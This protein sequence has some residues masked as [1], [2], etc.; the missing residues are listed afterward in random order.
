MRNRIII[1]LT[2]IVIILVAIIMFLTKSKEVPK[3]ES[4][5]PINWVKIGKKEV[6]IKKINI[7]ETLISDI[8]SSNEL[9]TMEVD[10][11]Q[12]LQWD[13]S[14]GNAG[15]LKKI[16]EVTFYGTGIYT[17]DLSSIEEEDI[18]VDE[19]K[20]SILI[21]IN[22]PLIKQVTID[23]KKTEIKSTENGLLRFGEVKMTIKDSERL[24]STAKEKM[25]YKMT[26]EENTSL[27]NEYTKSAVN[28]LLSNFL[29][30]INI[31]YNINI[32]W[33]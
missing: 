33:K 15:I 25:E 17:T 16:Q 7:K 23:E 11:S 29:K 14:W 13:I 9:I 6:T 31:K 22:K 19:E 2:L 24:R 12:T 21:K 26:L 8:K 18:V 20:E 30:A 27:A 28:E 4:T 32:E 5:P 1:T 10:L 3:V